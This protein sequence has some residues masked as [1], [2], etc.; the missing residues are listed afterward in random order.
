MSTGALSRLPHARKRARDASAGGQS[1]AHGPE[2]YWGT[3]PA[4]ATSG[5]REAAAAAPTTGAAGAGGGL[6]V[7]VQRIVGTL[8][9]ASASSTD[10]RDAPAV[11]NGAEIAGAVV[12]SAVLAPSFVGG[13]DA[14]PA[15]RKRRI[16][17]ELS[18]HSG[19]GGSFTSSVAASGGGGNVGT[20]VDL[21]Q[22][23]RLPS[24]A[25]AAKWY[26]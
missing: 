9:G 7:Q 5:A 8:C 23:V 3:S 25:S 16:E 18:G 21:I 19:G 4:R 13:P 2:V 14:A 22:T 10:G 6:E 1:P 11:L 12:G 24:R 26:V 17:I 20:I 15:R